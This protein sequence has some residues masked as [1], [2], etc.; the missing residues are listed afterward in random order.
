MKKYHTGYTAGVY[1]MFHIGHLN[2]IA[3]A[4]SLCEKLIVAVSTDE[5]VKNEKGVVPIHGKLFCQLFDIYFL[6]V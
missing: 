3:N 4:K 5:L 1:D 2:V 6:Q